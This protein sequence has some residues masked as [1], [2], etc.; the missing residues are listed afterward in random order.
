MTCHVSNQIADLANEPEEV[1]C[2]ACN[3][4]MEEKHIPG[5]E[6]WLQC[7]EPTCAEVIDLSE[8]V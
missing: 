5:S 2:P 3:G 7:L 4:E 8:E 1:R 6:Y